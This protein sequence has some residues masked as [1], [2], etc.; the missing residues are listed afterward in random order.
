MSHPIALKD[1]PTARFRQKILVALPQAE[2]TD[3]ADDGLTTLSFQS[4]L[5]PDR[6]VWTDTEGDML[7]ID[8]PS[9]SPTSASTS[10]ANGPARHKSAKL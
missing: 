10:S 9:T 3:R 7:Q 4:K 1:K 2:E 8:P 5:Y 6:Q